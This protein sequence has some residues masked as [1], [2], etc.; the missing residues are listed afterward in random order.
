M[1]WLS[2]ACVFTLVLLVAQST[3]QS[4]VNFL[5][6]SLTTTVWQ[7]RDC[8][9]GYASD[10]YVQVPAGTQIWISTPPGPCTGSA[11]SFWYAFDYATDW[12]N[13]DMSFFSPCTCATPPNRNACP[14]ENEDPV[15]IFE[16]AEKY[17]AMQ[18]VTKPAYPLDG[19]A[20]PGTYQIVAPVSLRYQCQG[21]AINGLPVGSTVVVSSCAAGTPCCQGYSEY[22]Q[23]SGYF[24][25]SGIGK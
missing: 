9:N 22:L 21:L 7:F 18:N 12:G 11:G 14:C 13:I 23:T 19:C 10:P 3:G 2:H 15:D 16:I 4:C 1:I 6:C 20:A 25:C 8:M 24:F 17:K 5:T